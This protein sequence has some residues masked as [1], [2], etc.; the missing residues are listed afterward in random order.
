MQHIRTTPPGAPGNVVEIP[1]TAHRGYCAVKD[2]VLE[3]CRYLKLSAADT[4]ACVDHAA[5]LKR[6]GRSSAVA[7]HEGIM[8]AKQ[9]A[10]ARDRA[11]GFT[12]PGA[13]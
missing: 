1:S 12:P 13:A 11:A 7:I 4:A 10:D 5:K 8:M 3:R 6:R 2:A 9:L